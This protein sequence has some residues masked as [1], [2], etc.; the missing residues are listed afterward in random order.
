VKPSA[1]IKEAMLR[2]YAAHASED[3]SAM[4]PHFSRQ[5]GVLA[6]GTDPNEWWAGFDTLAQI[7]KT[8]LSEMGGRVQI[9]AGDLQ[10]FA[11]GTVGWVADRAV[12]QVL[13]QRIPVRVTAVFQQEDGE[14]KIVQY[15]VSVGV[16]NT[17]VLGKE[18]TT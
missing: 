6:I 9:E 4:L 8:Q 5:E 16:P 3:A 1:E 10:A 2:V 12:L 18:L 17:E 11:E 14:W 13:G 7:Y 15:H